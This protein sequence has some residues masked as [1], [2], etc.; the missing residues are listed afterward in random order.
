M[1]IFS[2]CETVA[3]HEIWKSASAVMNVTPR[4]SFFRPDGTKAKGSTAPS[5]LIAFG[6]EAVSRLRNQTGIYGALCTEWEWKFCE[7]PRKANAGRKSRMG[8]GISIPQGSEEVRQPSG[9]IS[10]AGFSEGVSETEG[11]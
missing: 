8:K 10:L 6:T 5:S 3:W 11:I 1:L 7:K 4:I 2:R 9:Q